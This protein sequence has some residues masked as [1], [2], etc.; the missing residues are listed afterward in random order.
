MPTKQYNPT[1]RQAQA[2]LQTLE[3]RYPEIHKDTPKSIEY[4]VE[5][6]II[7]ASITFFFGVRSSNALF[8]LKKRGGP[9]AE[10]YWYC[11]RDWQ[12]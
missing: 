9:S 2:L 7:A 10:E 8:S 11:E 5:K 1:D 4:T 3:E 12:D 6:G